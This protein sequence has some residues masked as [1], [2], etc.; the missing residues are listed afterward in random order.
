MMPDPCSCA[1]P[2]PMLFYAAILCYFIVF[3]SYVNSIGFWVL[4]Y[5]VSF[6]FFLFLFLHLI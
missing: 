4:L 1:L 2:L 3:V 5:Y 6:P